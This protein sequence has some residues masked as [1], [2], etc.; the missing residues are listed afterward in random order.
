MLQHFCKLRPLLA[1]SE[2]ALVCCAVA[3][4]ARGHAAGNNTYGMQHMQQQ[5][6]Q[7]APAGYNPALQQQQQQQALL[8]QQQQQMASTLQ[9]VSASLMLL[10]RHSFITNLIMRVYGLQMAVDCLKCALACAAYRSF[11]C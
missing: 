11:R 4:Q 1:H 8:Q 2:F 6:Q 7:R 10:G 3:H 9:R 5:Q